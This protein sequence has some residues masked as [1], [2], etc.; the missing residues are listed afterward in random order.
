MGQVWFVDGAKI[1]LNWV[2]FQFLKFSKTRLS[3]TLT[4][5]FSFSEL[6]SFSRF[7]VFQSHGWTRIKN[8]ERRIPVGFLQG[9]WFM[10]IFR[11]QPRQTGKFF[12]WGE[13]A[14]LPYQMRCW[15][16]GCPQ[17]RLRRGF[18]VTRPPS[19]ELRRD[20]GAT[21]AMIVLSSPVT[22]T[23]SGEKKTGPSRFR[24]LFLL[25]RFQGGTRMFLTRIAP[26]C[27]LQTL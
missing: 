17:I 9:I 11:W 22:L 19:L 21:M 15:Q 16:D 25:L 8:E 3:H 10:G 2:R 27:F 1:G 7:Y 4:M 12:S 13:A 5:R 14:A 24:P 18:G 26:E 20:T 6:G 23:G